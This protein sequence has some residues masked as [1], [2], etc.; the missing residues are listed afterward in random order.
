MSISC[1]EAG[2]KGGLSR[3]KVKRE[4][5]ARNLESARRIRALIPEVEKDA[6]QG[7]LAAK[8]WLVDASGELKHLEDP[9]SVGSPILTVKIVDGVM[10]N[11][12][13]EIKALLIAEDKALRAAT[14]TTPVL[15]VQKVG[16]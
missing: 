6:A 14:K 11:N 16:D 2:R 1:S 7:D 15:T 12:Y 5:S 4:T 8:Q 9:A 10:S 3:S 13:D